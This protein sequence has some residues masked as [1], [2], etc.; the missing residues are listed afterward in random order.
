MENNNKNGRQTV[1]NVTINV[2]VSLTLSVTIVLGLAV[3]FMI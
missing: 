2:P 1:I 3:Y